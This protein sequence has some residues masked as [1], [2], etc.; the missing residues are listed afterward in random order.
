MNPVYGAA[1]C[2]RAGVILRGFAGTLVNMNYT[3]DTNAHEIFHSEPACHS[4]KQ[5]GEG[6]AHGISFEKTNG[7]RRFMPYALLCSAE[8]N[9]TYMLRFYFVGGPIT[10]R[11]KHLE[12][13]WEAICDCKLQRLSESRLP[14]SPESVWVG[15]IE[16]EHLFAEPV[17]NVVGIREE[18]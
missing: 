10:V 12:R 18:P 2:S 15:E 11:G 4:I 8:S 17:R 13:L 14:S 1:Y 9:S 6:L 5:A 3:D 7:A 16:A